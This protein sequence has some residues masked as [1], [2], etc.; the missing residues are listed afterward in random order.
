MCT[1]GLIRGGGVCGL[2]LCRPHKSQRK[3]SQSKGRIFQDDML[4]HG[5]GKF[6]VARHEEVQRIGHAAHG[7]DTR[8]DPDCPFQ[9]VQQFLFPLAVRLG[10]ADIIQDL[11]IITRPKTR[12]PVL[13]GIGDGVR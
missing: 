9:G 1:G 8:P 4:C 10:Y 5:F 7:A 3:V 12:H 2:S 6:Q 11:F 13:L